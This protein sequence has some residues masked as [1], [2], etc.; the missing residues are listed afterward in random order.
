MKRYAENMIGL[1][2]MLNRGKDYQGL[3]A[4]RSIIFRSEIEQILVIFLKSCFL[5][6][7]F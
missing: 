7:K 5:C 1:G 2:L 3:K 6:F 4:H